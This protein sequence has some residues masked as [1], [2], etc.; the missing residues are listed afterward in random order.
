MTSNI[1]FKA[2]AAPNDG[3][4]AD[5]DDDDDDDGHRRN[6]METGGTAPTTF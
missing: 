5:D 4:D 3:V 1:R 2:A 6:N